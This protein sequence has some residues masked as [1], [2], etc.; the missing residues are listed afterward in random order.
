[1][2]VALRHQAVIIVLTAATGKHY[3]ALK[4]NVGKHILR[5]QVLA[6]ARGRPDRNDAERVTGGTE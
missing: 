5:W 3:M 6:L 1:M 4:C 2:C